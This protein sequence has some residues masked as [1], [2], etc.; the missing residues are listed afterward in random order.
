MLFLSLQKLQKAIR[1][2]LSPCYVPI[3]LRNLNLSQKL[4]FSSDLYRKHELPL[5]NKG[6]YGICQSQG[7][8]RC[9]YI[10]FIKA[11]NIS[12]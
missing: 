4:K 9:A 8:D 2:N 6:I 5:L 7:R 1:N 3:F 10:P 11:K 12:L